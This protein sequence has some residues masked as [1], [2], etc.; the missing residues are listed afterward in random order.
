MDNNS[1]ELLFSIIENTNIND[2]IFKVKISKL[3]SS[4]NKYD[5][6]FVNLLIKLIGDNKIHLWI[7]T[8]LV[9][10]LPNIK[11]KNHLKLSNA[12]LSF[13][14]ANDEFVEYLIS[15][16]SLKKIDIDTDIDYD[17]FESRKLIIN[18]KFNII[19]FNY[20]MLV[21]YAIYNTSPLYLKNNKLCTIYEN[22]EIQTQREVP[23]EE[24][25]R[26]KRVF[27]TPH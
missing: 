24:I 7:R 10:A 17:S 20:I 12:L 15:N 11:T 22:Q 26:V 8:N 25:E 1:I 6:K 9:K 27:L 14:Q 13:R 4:L 3:I 19:D 5:D 18:D 23:L 16:K 2:G 21:R